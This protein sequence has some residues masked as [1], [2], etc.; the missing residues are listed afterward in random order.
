MFLEIIADTSDFDPHNLEIGTIV[1]VEFVLP[2]FKKDN[3]P[4]MLQEYYEELE[5]TP[6]DI[7]SRVHVS[8]EYGFYYNLCQGDFKILDELD[9]EELKA[10]DI[11][12]MLDDD[13]SDG[14]FHLHLHHRSD[15]MEVFLLCSELLTR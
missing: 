8:D 15:R 11:I 12:E 6:N 9:E 14:Y 7:P 10:G 1:T 4:I 3:L 2:S 13:I 5:I